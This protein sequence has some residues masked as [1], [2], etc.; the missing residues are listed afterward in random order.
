MTTNLSGAALAFADGT[1]QACAKGGIWCTV[2]GTANAVAL[3]TGLS[4]TTTK[5]FELR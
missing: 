1:L 2:G 3:T 5:R 4:L